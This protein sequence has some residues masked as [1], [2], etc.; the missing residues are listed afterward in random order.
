MHTQAGTCTHSHMCLPIDHYQLF[1]PSGPGKVT[2]SV[3]CSEAGISTDVLQTRTH[4]ASLVKVLIHACVFVCAHIFPV[5]ILSPPSCINHCPPSNGDKRTDSLKHLI[6]PQTVP[7]EG[8]V[9]SKREKKLWRKN[10][11]SEIVVM[12]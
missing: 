9:A 7:N 11:N 2:V 4:T 1:F 12:K 6:L 10:N 5:C 8:M 3:R